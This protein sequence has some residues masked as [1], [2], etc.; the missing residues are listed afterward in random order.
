MKQFEIFYHGKFTVEANNYSDAL[1]KAAE[2]IGHMPGD[3]DF[4]MEELL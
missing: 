3:S 2:E 4:T 1:D